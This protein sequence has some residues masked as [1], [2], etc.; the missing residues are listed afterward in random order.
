[1]G[2]V[3]SLSELKQIIRSMDGRGYGSYKRLLNLVVDYGTAELYFTKVQGDPHAPPSIAEVI[4]P[5]STHRLPEE[6]LKPDY[7][8]PFTD[9]IARELYKVTKSIRRKCGSGN[10]C[11]VGIPKPGPWVLKRSC[12]EIS[13][14]NLVLRFYVGLPARGRKVFGSQAITL[15]LEDIPKIIEHI[16]GLRSRLGELRNHIRNYVDQEYLRKWL[17]DSGYVGFISNGSILPRESSISER[18]MKNAVP[19]KSPEALEVAVKLP[20]GSVVRGMGIPK[21]LTVVT[22]GGYHGK[23]TLLE[24]LQEGIYNHVA[25]DGREYVVSRRYTVLVRAEDGRIVSHV[26]IS[27]LIS[28]LPSGEDTSDFIS[29]DASGSTSMAA[30]ISEVIE[31]GAEVI[32]IDE[33]T[34]ATNLLYKDDVMSKLIPDDPIRTLDM[35]VRDLIRKTG[36][37]V[38]AVMSASSSFLSV[39]DKVIRMRRYLP[40]EILNLKTGDGGVNVRSKEYRPPK[41]RLFYGISDIRKVKSSGYKIVTEYVDG[42][43]F[44]LDL[45]YYPRIVEKGQVKFIT[46][47]IRKIS[48]IK[49]PMRVRELVDF[50]NSL[51]SKRSFSAFADPV[52]PD[53]TVVD[54]FDVVWVLNRF[55]KALFT[56]V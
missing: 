33:D 1:V 3:V 21:G 7:L 48:R 27:S 5:Y 15:L 10:S 12:V 36:I 31:A 53:L 52:P 38:V 56:Q 35:Q 28:M 20:S 19:F 32:L 39:A 51:I 14:R 24:A 29:L 55:Y 8:V 41:E 54:G 9:F 25:G 46:F 40:E 13:S 44:E 30:S 34:S 17:Y 45:S 16:A 26:D 37:S 50:I 42:E 18:P 43:R 11:Y 6:L 23:T 2:R 22:G 49:K 4:V 47:I